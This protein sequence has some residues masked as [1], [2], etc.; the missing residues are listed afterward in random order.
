[1]IIVDSLSKSFGELVALHN[2]SFILNDG[3]ILGLIGKNGSGKTTTFRLL[4]NFLK[5]DQGGVQINGHTVDKLDY[6][7]IGYLPEEHGLY[8]KFT[9]KEQIMYFAM[10]KGMSKREIQKKIQPWL[11][12]FEVKATQNSR[13]SNLSKG[14]QQKVQLITTLIHQ[15]K[16]ILLDEPFSGLDPINAQLLQKEIIRQKEN[17]ASVIF[18]SHDMANVESI[19]DKVL[20]LNKGKTV[21]NGATQE[22]RSSF[23]YLRLNVV[24]RLSAQKIREIPGVLDSKSI[25]GMIS[26]RVRD[27]ETAETVFKVIRKETKVTEFSQSY[28]SLD[29]IFKLK[30]SE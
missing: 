7:T 21:L 10:L 28:P 20:M 15:P 30:G 29:E 1:M 17:G 13:I 8:Q 24:A 5:A 12:K 3:E 4:L 25:N 16:I 27:E 2:E 18:S 23:G 6:R 11:D 22:I 26:L 9:V 14:N 19:S